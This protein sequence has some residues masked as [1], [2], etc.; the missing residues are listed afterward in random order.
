MLP[1]EFQYFFL[2]LLVAVVMGRNGA[3]MIA[4]LVITTGNWQVALSSGGSPSS[5]NYAAEE[6]KRTSKQ[7]S[8]LSAAEAT[9]AGQIG[10]FL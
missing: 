8:L 6:A 5:T 7:T 10:I 9:R 3:G 2:L 4:H 1:G